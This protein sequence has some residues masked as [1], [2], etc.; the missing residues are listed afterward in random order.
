MITYADFF[1]NLDSAKLVEKL[2][3]V[4]LIDRREKIYAN[5]IIL[6]KLIVFLRWEYIVI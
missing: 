4:M 5:S 1:L 6:K 3:L 2:L